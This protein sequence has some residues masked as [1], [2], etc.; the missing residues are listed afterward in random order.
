MGCGVGWKK[1][2]PEVVVGFGIIRFQADGFLELVD[3][4]VGLAFSAEGDAEIVVGFGVIRFD[5]EGFPELLDG[6]VQLTV[7]AAV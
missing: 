5:A 6:R 1:A 2:T 4:F 3:G 7:P